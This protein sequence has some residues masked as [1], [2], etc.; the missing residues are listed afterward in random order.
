MSMSIK[1]K[2]QYLDKHFKYWTMNSWN[3][4]ESFA[5]NIKV[6]NIIPKD[7][8]NKA[9]DLLSV[10][11]PAFWEYVKTEIDGIL[12]EFCGEDYTAYINGRSGGYLVLGKEGDF[13]YFS[14]RI[15]D[16]SDI[17]GLYENGHYEDYQN[18]V[19]S[20]GDFIDS[21]FHTVRQFKRACGYIQRFYIET[22]KTAQIEQIEVVSTQKIISY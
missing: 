15:N 21:V 1:N 4:S 13:S 22:I 19:E 17:L 10:D 16:F 9:Y 14:N 20:R 2:L 11:D 7:L 6:Y 5:F 18:E 8:R 12:K 3:R